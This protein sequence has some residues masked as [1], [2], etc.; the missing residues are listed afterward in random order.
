MYYPTWCVVNC[1][2]RHRKICGSCI[3]GPNFAAFGPAVP[4]SVDEV[5]CRGRRCGGGGAG[6]AAVGAGA[7]GSR[8]AAGAVQS[9]A[10]AAQDGDAAAARGHA[11][12]SPPQG[13]PT[14]AH[15]LN[16]VGP[17]GGR[18]RGRLRA[19]RRPPLQLRRLAPPERR[20]HRRGPPRLVLLAP[21]RLRTA[22]RRLIG[23]IQIIVLSFYQF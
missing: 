8:A 12:R 7:R 16:G 14:N 6:A 1:F 3:F 23:I 11:A 13:P 18:G 21:H 5:E 10:A 19:G 4:H 20:R 9:Q 2:L 15:G 17:A 22:A